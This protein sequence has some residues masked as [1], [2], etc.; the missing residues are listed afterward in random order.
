MKTEYE[1]V[2]N[3]AACQYEYHVEGIW[4]MSSMKRKTAYCI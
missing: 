1:L 3:E 2:H 4:H